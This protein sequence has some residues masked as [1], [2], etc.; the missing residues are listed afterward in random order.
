[1]ANRFRGH[2]AQLNSIA[3]IFLNQ[4]VEVTVAL[5]NLRARQEQL[6]H[7]DWQ[8]DAADKFYAEMNG[9]VRPA[10]QKLANALAEAAIITKKIARIT[11]D[12]EDTSSKVFVIVVS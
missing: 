9:D 1:M 6:E 12:T 8:G 4:G 5:H 11:K 2:Y 10:L 7:G 3:N